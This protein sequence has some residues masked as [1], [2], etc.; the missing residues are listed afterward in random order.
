VKQKI[1]TFLTYNDRAEEAVGF[2]VS[3]FR[4]S[5]ILDTM[6]AGDRVISLQFELEGQ[7]F[8]ALNGGPSFTFAQ[9][10][11]LFV[12]C[13]TQR[14]ID[15]LY[16]KLSAGGEKQPC[17]WLRDR[18]GV[19]WQVVPPLLGQLLGDKDRAKADRVLQAMLKMQKIEIA[20]LEKA[21]KG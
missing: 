12:A 3:V 5:R 18:F 21:A 20:A 11:S 16:E 2:Y 14:E 17:G 6:R 10:I 8:V 19:S 15:E 4:N 1:T 13:D 7:E 9:G